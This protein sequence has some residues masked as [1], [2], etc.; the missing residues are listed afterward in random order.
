MDDTPQAKPPLS[1]AAQR[2]L[3]EAAARR[4]EIDEK[5]AAGKREKG[6]RGGLDPA[7][8]GDWEIKGLTA[9]F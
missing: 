7:R 6:G 3:D 1:P 8:Y 4:A 2:A 5:A 9:D